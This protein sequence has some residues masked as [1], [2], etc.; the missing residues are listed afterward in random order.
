MGYYFEDQQSMFSHVGED[1]QHSL[2][3]IVDRYIN[4]NPEHSPTCRAFYNRGILRGADY[5]SRAD[6]NEFFPDAENEQFVY[7]WTK[8]WSSGD[9]SLM[10]DISCFGPMIIWCNGQEV[11]RSNIFTE[12]YP[13]AKHRA[14]IAQKAGWNHFV[15][16]FKKTRGGFGGIFGSWLGK[17]PYV[18]MMPSPQRQGQEGWLYTRP[19]S[20]ELPQLPGEGTNE[21]DSSIKWLPTVAWDR[22]QLKMGQLQ[23]IYGS[24]PSTFAIGW[25]KANVAQLGQYKI[26]GASKGPVTVYVGD[27]PVFTAKSSGTIKAKIELGAGV[28]DI[29]VRSDCKGSDWGFDLSIDN[30]ELLSPCDLQGSKQKWIYIGPF[31][32]N[33]KLDLP[34]LRDLLKVHPAIHGKTYWRIDEPDTWVRIYNENA[35]YGRW[36]YPLGVTLYG[37]LNTARAID[38]KAVEQYVVNHNKLCAD[39]FEYALWDRSQF[40]GATNVHH[41][42]ASIDSLDDCGSFGSVFLEVAKDHKI[43]GYREIVDYVADYIS[44]MQDRQPD[45][46]FYRKKMM[47]IFHENTM[48]ADDLYM[49]VPF[50]CRYYQ[51]TGD[52]K[53]IDDAARQFIGF[54]KRLF[55]PEWQVMSH[56]FDFR[57]NIATGVPWGRGNGWT[58]FSLS[59]LLAVLPEKHPQRPALLQFFR[60]LAAGYLALQDKDGMW[61]QVLTHH[62]SYPE[63]SCTSMFTYAFCRGVRFGWLP[64]PR[65]YINAARKA[66]QALNKIAIDKDGNIFGVC[67]GSEFSFTP[68]YYKKELSWNLNDTHGVGIVLLAGVEMLRLAQHLQ[69]RSKEKN[70]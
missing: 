47:H 25:V 65:P 55:I 45:G 29:I 15:I 10:F 4:A 9:A 40:G 23:R 16:R 8:H 59:E 6:F 52:K 39:T 66:W 27:R 60:E 32:N 70:K 31:K 3:G 19:M 49:S 64:K 61:H 12:R 7:A 46:C 42:L 48:W 50:L 58:I 36:N 18:F 13:D 63:S 28:H 68:E 33:A 38:S 11:W 1:V 37:M 14:T 24:Q 67:R 21:S 2:S 26:K 20:Q 17:H 5:R 53:Y 62:D 56:I 41:L 43:E 54:K 51:L 30:A 34:S 57:R 22:K 44:N 35:L 69:P